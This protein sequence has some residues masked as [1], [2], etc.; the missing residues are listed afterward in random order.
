ML[1]HAIGFMHEHFVHLDPPQL[2]AIDAAE[3]D[4]KLSGLE[5]LTV[6]NQ[7]MRGGQYPLRRDQRAAAG[8]GPAAV[9]VRP[10][11]GDQHL[12]RDLAFRHRLA[13]DDH[14]AAWLVTGLR[15]CGAGEAERHQQGERKSKAPSGHGRDS[16]VLTLTNQL[17]L[18]LVSLTA[19]NLSG[20]SGG[21][22]FNLGNAVVTAPGRPLG[23]EPPQLRV[24][25]IGRKAYIRAGAAHAR[26][27]PRSSVG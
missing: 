24:K 6:A 21:S 23:L 4:L 10:L 20:G 11:R 26:Q 19:G 8:R 14:L 25:Q 18:A 3:A 13:V 16:E 7:A 2:G 22:T 9:L 17:S 27:G 1:R 15:Q 5:R 12:K